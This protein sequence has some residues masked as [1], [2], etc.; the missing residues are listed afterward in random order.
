[1]ADVFVSYARTDRA[2]VLPYA[3]ADP[4]LE[5]L[6]DEPRFHA[7]IAEAEARLAKEARLQ[8]AD[9]A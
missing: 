5:L 1:M 7:M 2:R 3:K 4:D 6:R 9:T 8:A